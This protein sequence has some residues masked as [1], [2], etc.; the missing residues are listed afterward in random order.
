[1]SERVWPEPNPAGLVD[2]AQSS[3][4]AV[5]RGRCNLALGIIEGSG[6]LLLKFLEYLESHNAGK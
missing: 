4:A 6:G 3:R 5:T 2:A 1:V